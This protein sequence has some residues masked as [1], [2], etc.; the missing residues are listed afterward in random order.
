MTFTEEEFNEL[1]DEIS[2]IFSDELGEYFKFKRSTYKWSSEH[3]FIINLDVTSNWRKFR[4]LKPE[5]KIR[6]MSGMLESVK[7]FINN[8]EKNFTFISMHSSQGFSF[9]FVFQPTSERVKKL[10]TRKQ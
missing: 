8:E 2:N 10:L 9:G 5:K 7:D 3:D 1:R 4:E 6:L